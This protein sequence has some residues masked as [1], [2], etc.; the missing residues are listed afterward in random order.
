[1]Q[2]TAYLARAARF[3]SAWAITFVA[4]LW[5]FF[6]LGG[7]ARLVLL[8]LAALPVWLLAVAI[9]SVQLHLRRTGDDAS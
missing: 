4:W 7:E 3:A 1:M 6:Q 8:V 9:Q 2:K 5:A